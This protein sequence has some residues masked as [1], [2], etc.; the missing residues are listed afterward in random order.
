MSTNSTVYGRKDRR[1]SGDLEC[2]KLKEGC[3]ESQ[4]VAKSEFMVVVAMCQVDRSCEF[5]QSLQCWVDVFWCWT[6]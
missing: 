4:T 3:E 5:D 1:S 6:S 2:G